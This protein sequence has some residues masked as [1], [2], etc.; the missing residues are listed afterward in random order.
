MAGY[1]EG[2]AAGIEATKK[3]VPS[4]MINVNLGGGSGQSE[5]AY[6]CETHA[7]T[8]R[9]AA[10]GA[11]EIEARESVKAKCASE[12]HEMHCGNATC[13]RNSP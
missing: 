4:T 13:R 3:P 6:F 1:R 10:F 12:Y 9:F 11:T 2:Y 8:K 7:F 5:K